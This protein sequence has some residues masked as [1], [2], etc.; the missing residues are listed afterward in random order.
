MEDGVGIFI[1]NS[2]MWIGGKIAYALKYKMKSKDCPQW[3]IKMGPLVQHLVRGRKI[4]A[5]GG[6]LF[7]STP[8]PSPQLWEQFRKFIK[9]TTYPR[10]KFTNKEKAIDV[11]LGTSVVEFACD[12]PNAT[13]IL[14]SGDLD[15]VSVLNKLKKRNHAIEVWGWR[16]SYATGITNF[17]YEKL[18]INYLDDIID[19]IGFTQ[20]EWNQSLEDISPELSMVFPNYAVNST[21]IVELLE[22]INTPY[23][24]LEVDNRDMVIIFKDGFDDDMTLEQCVEKGKE[25]GCI[26]FLVW[27]QRRTEAT[28]TISC[29]LVP[30][31]LHNSYSALEEE[32][33]DNEEAL[34][35]TLKDGAMNL[36]EDEK[37][38]LPV[39]GKEKT[40]G[41]G[42]IYELCRMGKYCKR[43]S[44]GKCKR[45]HS[46]VVHAYFHMTGGS[47]KI[48]QK[49]KAC[50]KET[51]HGPTCVYWHEYLNE[52]RLCPTC[53]TMSENQHDFAHC[54]VYLSS[55]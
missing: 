4:L 36:I 21:K 28:Y 22:V 1:D 24:H 54:P 5:D 52:P 32:D 38:W 43:Y 11:D 31:F 14:V 3:R 49:Y 37:M 9:V 23:H 47:A 40:K 33:D 17:Q 19:I 27:K 44:T 16:K 12:N 42:Q 30:I 26:P 35:E 6:Q 53:D 20:T 7:G 48:L 10:N 15:F 8:P 18:S 39:N 13:I 2:N 34:G 41:H 29:R 50:Q 46:K 25:Y 45:E 55:K 51:C